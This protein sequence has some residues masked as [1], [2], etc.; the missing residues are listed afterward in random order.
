[1]GGRFADNAQYFS[2]QPQFALILARRKKAINYVKYCNESC[3]KY[4][5][6]IKLKT[7]GLN[8]YYGKYQALHNINLELAENRVTA[9]IGASGCGKSTLLRTFNRI[10]NLYPEQRPEGKIFWMAVI[11]WIKTGY[12]PP[13]RKIGMVFQ[14]LRLFHGIFDNV[15]Y[16]VRLYEKLPRGKL[17]VRVEEALQKPH[18]GMK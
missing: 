12:K 14:N 8:F 17:E 6:K 2:D 18:C 15:A 5:G 9:F 3:G 16:G 7:E 10:Y 1:M 13:A 4:R 11:F